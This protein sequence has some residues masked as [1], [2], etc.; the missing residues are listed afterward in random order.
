MAGDRGNVKPSAT[1]Q[2]ANSG[3]GKFIYYNKRHPCPVCN[4]TD[5]KCS[6]PRDNP[7][8]VLCHRARADTNGY[9]YVKPASNPFWNIFAP[10]DGDN[11]YRQRPISQPVHA[12]QQP[13]QKAAKPPIDPAR[14]FDRA[15]AEM[16]RRGWGEAFLIAAE[17]LGLSDLEESFACVPLAVEWEVLRYPTL[18][19]PMFG[20]NLVMKSLQR[21]GFEWDR[22]ALKV[23]SLK[24][25]L[26]GCRTGL[27]LPVNRK[28]TNTV[29]P[30]VEGFSDMICL[31]GL[32]VWAIGTLSAGA[33]ADDLREWAR[34]NPDAELL[35]VVENDQ[36]PDGRWP[37]MEGRR[38]IAAEL[39]KRGVKC[40]LALTPDG[41]KDVR[42]WYQANFGTGP[43]LCEHLFEHTIYD[44][45][46]VQSGQELPTNK[47]KKCPQLSVYNG[48]YTESCGHFD[49]P[50]DPFDTRKPCRRA[51]T[52]ALRERRVPRH[53]A[54]LGLDEQDVRMFGGALPSAERHNAA[55]DGSCGRRDCTACN[56][57]IQSDNQHAIASF[58]SAHRLRVASLLECEHKEWPTIRR[59]LSRKF[60]LTEDHFAFLRNGNKVLIASVIP[61]GVEPLPVSEA[62][63][64]VKAFVRDMTPTVPHQCF[65]RVPSLGDAE[66][67]EEE[68][69]GEIDWEREGVYA[70][71]TLEQKAILDEEDVP[72]EWWD[73]PPD[74][75]TGAFQWDATAMTPT[76]EELIKAKL[77]LKKLPN[78]KKPKPEMYRELDDIA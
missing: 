60:G 14:V 2:G 10:D 24:R 1:K 40:S 44:L 57:R 62:W 48:D 64:T 17:H 50:V 49:F 19:A 45:P 63:G 35:L 70:K 29:V 73:N 59:R 16:E 58:L 23:K 34:N 4:G 74:G 53:L 15:R 54:K 11:S 20:G 12:R 42:A 3:G 37:S 27:F 13:A 56:P 5:G 8:L 67:E 21:Y 47:T 18:L 6:S 72:V 22:E 52:L 43:I 66:A 32:G 39:A 7:R 36:K 33:G 71:D 41:K 78:G 38:H 31:A 25:N 77:G 9:R 68:G 76:K 75:I 65:V 69:E 26:P 61:I 51:P 55:L 28:R 46:E 30:V